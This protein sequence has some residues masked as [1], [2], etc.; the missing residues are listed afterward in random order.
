MKLRISVV[1]RSG[2]VRYVEPGKNGIRW[3]E[4]GL[5]W[6]QAGQAHVFRPLSGRET[7]VVILTGVA[8]VRGD[9][10]DWEHLGGRRSVFEGPATALYFP[11][12]TKFKVEAETNLEAAVIRAPA[13][14]GAAAAVI[15]P[16]DVV[17]HRSRGGP[18]FRRDV[19]DIIVDQVPA[20]SLLVG[21]TFN[22]PGEWSSYPP[23]KHDQHRPPE[24]YELEEIYFYK[25]DPPQ[26]FGVQRIYS[27]ERGIDD[28]FPVLNNDLV[29]IPWGY[30]PVAAAPGYRLYYLWALAGRA[31]VLYPY[32]DPTHA[33]ILNELQS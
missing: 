9:D 20:E 21:E 3:L 22:Y 16:Q 25:V 24:E 15:R 5:L 10:F 26:G 31:R 6:L 2:Y 13:K 17:V 11:P 28:A 14:Q 27:P 32:T 29:L 30:H 8:R 23:H 4:F 1:P 7:A 33:W 18:G 19:H 12:N